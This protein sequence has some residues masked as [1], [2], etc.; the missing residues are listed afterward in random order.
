MKDGKLMAV[1]Q[2]PGQCPLEEV[3]AAATV[4]D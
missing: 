1:G 2:V 3:I 4:R